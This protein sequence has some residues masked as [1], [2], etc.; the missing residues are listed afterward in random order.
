MKKVVERL[1]AGESVTF[2]PR[3]KSMEPLIHDGQTVTVVPWDGAQLSDG[4]VVLCKV[5]GKTYLHKILAHTPG[6]RYLIGNNKGHT[7]GWTRTIYGVL[8]K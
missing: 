6:G 5:S 1:Q 8:K 2:N 4:T 3:G 7:N